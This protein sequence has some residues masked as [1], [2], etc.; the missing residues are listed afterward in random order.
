[1][2]IALIRHTAISEPYPDHDIP[3][4]MLPDVKLLSWDSWFPFE[5]APRPYTL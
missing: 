3:R 4:G 5:E 1:M 2:M